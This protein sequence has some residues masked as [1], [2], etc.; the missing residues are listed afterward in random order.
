MTRSEFRE[1]FQRALTQAAEN[2]QAKFSKS[3]PASFRIELHA[4]GF[5]GRLVNV[6]EAL[7]QIYLGEDR[8]YRI[9]DI[10]IK[11]V[12]LREAVVFLRVSGH[13]PDVF[14][15]TWDPSGT[16]PFKQILASDIGT[17]GP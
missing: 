14:S 10:A 16:G 17:R 6:E 5:S 3:I 13:P 11:E 7:D 4:P 8:F 12:R 2:A 15:K 9:I 1:L